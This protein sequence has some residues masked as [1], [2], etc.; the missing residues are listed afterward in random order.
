MLVLASAVQAQTA[1]L[2][3]VSTTT[4]N[5]GSSWS[6]SVGQVVGTLVYSTVSASATGGSSTGSSAGLGCKLRIKVTVSATSG[7]TVS[8]TLRYKFHRN[9]SASAIASNHVSGG[10]ATGDGAIDTLAVHA[11]VPPNDEH[12]PA[13]QNDSADPKADITIPSSA[14]TYQNGVWTGYY[15]LSSHALSA[16][17]ILVHPTANWKDD[18]GA[19]A[20]ALVT[21]AV[22]ITNLVVTVS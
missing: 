10:S 11:H 5:A 2:E 8:A 14:F 18:E 7:S 6:R 9:R 22:L 17:G 16:S 20:A 4:T 19:G 12:F 21:S 3:H 13:P 15:D 1:T